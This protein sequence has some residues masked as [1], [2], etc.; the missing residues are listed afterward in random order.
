MCSYVCVW[1]ICIGRF[2][3]LGDSSAGASAPSK[4]S[5]RRK[6]SICGGESTIEEGIRDIEGIG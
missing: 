1:T 2:T 6:R 3:R 5:E 4:S